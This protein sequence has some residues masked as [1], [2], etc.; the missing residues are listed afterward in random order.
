ME[1]EEPKKIDLSNLG[2]KEGKEQETIATPEHGKK[3][4]NLLDLLLDVLKDRQENKRQS[5]VEAMA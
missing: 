1:Q 5:L 3:K 2:V 4:I